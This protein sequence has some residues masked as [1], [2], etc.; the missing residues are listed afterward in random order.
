MCESFFLNS[1]V[2]KSL[3]FSYPLQFFGGGPFGMWQN[4]VYRKKSCWKTPSCLKP[5]Y[6]SALLLWSLARPLSTHARSRC[7]FSRRDSRSPNPFARVSSGQGVMVLDD[8]M[9]EGSNDKPVLEIFT[10]HSQHQT[11]PRHVSCGQICQ[12]HFP[13]CP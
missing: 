1:H 5:S 11:L 3:S 7:D 10:K 13:Q 12:K 2:G 9:D 6:L 8:L 4:R